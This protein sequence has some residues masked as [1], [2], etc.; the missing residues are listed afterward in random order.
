MDELNYRRLMK[1]PKRRCEES[2]ATQYMDPQG[3]YRSIIDDHE[4]FETCLDCGFLVGWCE[5]APIVP[6]PPS[7]KKVPRAQADTRAKK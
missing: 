6:K 2:G 1:Y 5:C 7:K 4:R 3:I